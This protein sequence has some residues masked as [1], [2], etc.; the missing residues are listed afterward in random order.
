MLARAYPLRFFNEPKVS[1]GSGGYNNCTGC[2]AFCP[3]DVS[4]RGELRR[5]RWVEQ[6]GYESSSRY[7]HRLPN[8]IAISVVCSGFQPI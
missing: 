8:M 3:W 2:N 5:E 6:E 1:C 4:I 7:L